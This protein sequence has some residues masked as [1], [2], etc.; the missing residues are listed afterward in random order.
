MSSPK[1][2]KLQE[3]VFKLKLIE[4]ENK[5]QNNDKTPSTKK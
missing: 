5:D 2:N 1:S 3:L 4:N